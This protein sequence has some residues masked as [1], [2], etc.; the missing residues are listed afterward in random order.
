MPGTL[1]RVRG[2][3]RY[4]ERKTG[5]WYCYH[6]A[7]GKR[8][9]EEFGSAEFFTRLAALETETKEK[10]EKAARP[11]TFGALLLHYKRTDDFK[12][13]APRT[14][15]D[16]E[17]VF[18]FLEPLWDAPLSAFTT[19]ELAKLRTKWREKRGR[20]FVNYIRS[21]LSVVFVHGMDIGVMDSNPARD[22]KKIKRPRN[23]PD[24]N[25][26]WSL[27]ERQA[28][29]DHLAPHLRL[30]VAI[31]LYT[32]MREG[33]VLRLPRNVV[34]NSRINIKTRK[35]LVS[36]DIHVLP[37]LRQALE[38]APQH[39]AIT[40]CANSRGKPWTESGFRASFRKAL[41]ELERRERV[42]AGLQPVPVGRRD[43]A[44]SVDDGESHRCS[45]APTRG[46][47]CRIDCEKMA[48][49]WTAHHWE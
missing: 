41:K 45:V 11:G 23:A 48:W 17:K 34:T 8:I 47:I 31:S 21:V 2:I 37:G 7:T 13:L 33:D 4:F 29:L 49:P 9:T 39:D 42:A 19:V 46:V 38:A 15:R 12:D 1:V 18:A 28:V 3:K 20:H 27:S 26:P 35:R 40:L 22:L 43:P 30:P 16:Y 14:R 24:M 44:Q 32:G 25:R 6:R 5:K 10:T 36:I